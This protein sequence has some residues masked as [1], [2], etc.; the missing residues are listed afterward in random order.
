MFLKVHH[1]LPCLPVSQGLIFCLEQYGNGFRMV[2]E[3]SCRC[4][5]RINLQFGACIT[6]KSIL[7]NHLKSIITTLLVITC[8]TL[9]NITDTRG[10]VILF[11][12][13]IK[14]GKEIYVLSKM[15]RFCVLHNTKKNYFSPDPLF[16]LYS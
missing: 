3:Q 10:P 12:Q 8:K 2:I 1:S 7:I 6:C 5:K 11:K 16:C 4:F 9:V 14:W 15:I 13:H